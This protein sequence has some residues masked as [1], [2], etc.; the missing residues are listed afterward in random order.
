[1]PLTSVYQSTREHDFW[2]RL[3]ALKDDVLVYD[4][5]SKLAYFLPFPQSFA[6]YRY[7]EGAVLSAYYD[8][9]C[10]S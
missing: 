1:V 3:G 10:G 6:D 8:S 7:V 5:C 2:S 4:R 9:P